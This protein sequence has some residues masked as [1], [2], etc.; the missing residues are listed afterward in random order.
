MTYDMSRD[1]A[2]GLSYTLPYVICLYSLIQLICMLDHS[3]TVLSGISQAGMET[4]IT[5]PTMWLTCE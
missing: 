4:S 5:A 3:F 2:T 1:V